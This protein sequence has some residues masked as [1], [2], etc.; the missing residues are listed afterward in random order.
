MNA[1]S[2]ILAGICSFCLVLV[3]PVAAGAAEIVDRN[4]AEAQARGQRRQRRARHLFRGRAQAQRPLLGRGQLGR[5]LQARLLRRL[6]EQDRR[7]QALQQPLQALHGSGS[8]AHDRRVRRARRLALGAPAVG[9]PVG[10]LRRQQG[11]ERA[12]HLALARRHGASSRSRPTTATAA[13]TS[14]SGASSSSRASRSTAPSGRSAGV[15]LDRTGR[16]IYVDYLDGE[17][18]RVNSFLTHPPTAGFCY[19][20]ANHPGSTPAWNGQGTGD[21]YR[22]TAIGPASRRSSR[23]TS[24]RR[25]R[26]RRPATRP[27]TPRRQSCSAKTLAAASTRKRCMRRRQAL[28]LFALAGVTAAQSAQAAAPGRPGRIA[29]LSEP[30]SRAR[31]S[32]ASYRPA[33]LAAALG[34]APARLARRL[35]RARRPARRADGA[36]GRRASRPDPQRRQAARPRPWPR[37]R[38]VA[39]R[40][41]DRVPLGADRGLVDLPDPPRRHRPP[42]HRCTPRRARREPARVVARQPDADLRAAAQGASGA[43]DDPRRRH[44]LA[45]LPHRPLRL[46]ALVR[47]GRPPHR[48]HGLGQGRFGIWIVGADG[49]GARPLALPPGQRTT[50]GY[51]VYSP[52]GRSI[53]FVLRTSWARIAVMRS[54]GLGRRFVSP[55][56]RF[57]GGVDWARA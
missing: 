37:A 2:R 53:A 42:P 27:P 38:L 13:S 26:T 51:P 36:E 45:R 8:A 47:A 43:L 30:A 52:D 57:I 1:S 44:G 48:L 18:R 11:Q 40:P 19:T 9:A 4:V 16:N 17:W 6:E 50:F 31:S 49:R 15:P 22:A 5:A 55:R 56:T 3:L 21:A 14:T 10:Q 35:L 12:L 39:R 28:A 32:R 23:C 46:G 25:A 33:G 54:D 24:R 34:E 7:P 20:F 29:Y 41:L